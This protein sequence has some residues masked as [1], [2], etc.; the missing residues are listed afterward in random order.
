MSTEIL[1]RLR[2]TREQAQTL[3]VRA[4]QLRA[5]LFLDMKKGSLSSR[6]WWVLFVFFSG[7]RLWCQRIGKVMHGIHPPLNLLH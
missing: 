5:K 7:L 2:R 4:R 6:W 3:S 1:H